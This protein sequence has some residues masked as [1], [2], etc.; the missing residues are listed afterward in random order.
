[1]KALIFDLDETLI[2]RSKT[3]EPYRIRS[4]IRKH[5]PWFLINLGI[6]AKAK[7]VRVVTDHTI[8]IIMMVRYRTVI[9]VKL[10]KKDA[11]G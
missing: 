8:G 11:Y 5:L 3:M 6:C 2:D 1:M 10:R 4:R 9:T 7:T